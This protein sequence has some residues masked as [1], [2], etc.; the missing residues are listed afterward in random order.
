MTPKASKQGKSGPREALR[1]DRAS[2][3]APASGAA[4]PE[5][6]APR[7]RV[8]GEVPASWL[9]RLLGAVVDL[10]L[11]SG[12]EAVLNAMVDALAAIFP[13]YAVGAC[14]VPEP[15][16]APRGQLLVRRLPDGATSAVGDVD[17]TRVFPGLRHE[18]VVNIVES[19][20]GSTLHLASDDDD[21]GDLH[22]P[23][24]AL[25]ERA[26]V[27]L[28]RALSTARRMA[29]PPGVVTDG[30]D[31]E[32]R[33]IQ[34]DKLATFG[35][36]AAGIVHELNNPL[37]SI[38]AYSDYLIRKAVSHP[39]SPESSDPGDV[40][41]LRRI[42]ESANRMLRF[43]RD[44][45]T[46]ARPSSGVAGPVILHGVMDQ[47]V[48]FCEHVLAQAQVSVERHYACDVLTVRGV[49]EQLVQV[50][51]NLLTNASQAAPQ[52][53]GRIVLRTWLEPSLRRVKIVVED[54]GAGIPAE[55][56]RRV[57][58]P[59]FT[60]KSDRHG[61]GLGPSIVKSILDGHDGNIDVESKPGCG[62]RFVLELPVW[63]RA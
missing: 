14:F 32:Q 52:V 58:L 60:T 51:V 24:V 45:V 20:S 33:M 6:T 63:Q 18:R 41:R 36:I 34:A 43:T 3:P 61:T 22:A 9:D 62:A 8:P 2:D 21:V 56:L 10:P 28:G 12:E 59:F 57:F 4:A 44:F 55:N 46:Y 53:G 7:S 29:R 54:N 5:D 16:S 38:V 50:F 39:V 30:Q 49:G 40:D 47:A 42:S 27:A 19:T 11:E 15:S 35:Q 23:A 37:T 31:F 48:A 25:L 1:V 13:S 17:P 26:A